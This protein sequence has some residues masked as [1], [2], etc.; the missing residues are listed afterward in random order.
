M[1]IFCIFRLIFYSFIAIKKDLVFS[2]IFHSSVPY[3]GQFWPLLNIVRKLY[4]LL[5][6]F[7]WFCYF[8]L[9]LEL[10]GSGWKKRWERRKS[11]KKREGREERENDWLWSVV[12]FFFFFFFLTIFNKFLPS[13]TIFNRFW[14]L[15]WILVYFGR[16]WTVLDYFGKFWPFLTIFNH[17]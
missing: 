13:L 7:G 16:F 1:T 5:T 12:F 2:G 9:I 11:G 15:W 17:F 14:P 6:K 10:S 4:L 8:R 3:F